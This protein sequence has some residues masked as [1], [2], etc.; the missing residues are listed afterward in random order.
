MSLYPVLTVAFGSVIHP[1]WDRL[2]ST[3]DGHRAVEAADQDHTRRK[4]RDRKEEW[5]S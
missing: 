4:A 3:E 2:P 5:L 1:Q